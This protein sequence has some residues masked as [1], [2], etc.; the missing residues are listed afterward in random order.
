MKSDAHIAFAASN[1]EFVELSEIERF[2][3]D[4]G[5]VSVI[6]IGSGEFACSGKKFYFADLPG[7]LED[8]KTSHRAVRGRAELR[9]QYEEEFVRFEFTARGHVVVSGLVREYGNFDRMLR[10]G[11]EADQSFMPPF[12][13]SIER[14]VAA[15]K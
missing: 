11:F 14:V 15:L 8:L 4:S 3:D 6:R 12:L 10:F 9:T 5:Y 1:T 7:F 13:A 2:A